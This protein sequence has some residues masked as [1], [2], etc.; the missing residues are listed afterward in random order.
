MTMPGISPIYVMACG[1][2]WPSMARNRS[3]IFSLS[4]FKSC[5]FFLAMEADFGIFKQL[6]D[7]HGF[8]RNCCII[9]KLS[10]YEDIWR[11]MKMLAKNQRCSSLKATKSFCPIQTLSRNFHVFHV[12]PSTTCPFPILHLLQPVAPQCEPAHET[13]PTDSPPPLFRWSA[14]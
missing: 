9:F 11:C 4:A 3:M 7:I 2:N 6:V 1:D 5:L 14:C 8:C 10:V 13:R 12:Q